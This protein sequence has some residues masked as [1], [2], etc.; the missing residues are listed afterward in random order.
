MTIGR[1]G[2][3]PLGF[4]EQILPLLCDR[5]CAQDEG[6]KKGVPSLYFHACTDNQ[7][8]PRSLLSVYY[9]WPGSAGWL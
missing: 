2:R 1:R 5:S 8:N 4:C 7:M 3:L 6:D 9:L